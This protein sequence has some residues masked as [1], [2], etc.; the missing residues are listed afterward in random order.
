MPTEGSNLS[1]EA[2]PSYGVNVT[3][4]C[5]DRRK[6]KGERSEGS[7]HPPPKRTS[8]TSKEEMSNHQLPP[9]SP[10]GPLSGTP[11]LAPGG[12]SPNAGV[13]SPWTQK[14]S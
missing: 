2:V 1:G 10:T 12:T 11:S 4:T 8:A 9:P 6:R 14:A 13:T 7:M 5:L 3:E